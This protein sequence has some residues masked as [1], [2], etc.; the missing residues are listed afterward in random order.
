MPSDR[1]FNRRDFLRST[2][3]VGA[4]GTVLGVAGCGQSS[5]PANRVTLPGVEVQDPFKHGLASGDPT[6]SSVLL[7][8]RVTPTDLDGNFIPGDVTV[9]WSAYR[10]PELTELV[11]G[12]TTIARE[13]ND[14]CVKVAPIAL[15]LST[16]HPLLFIA[17]PLDCGSPPDPA[18]HP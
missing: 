13:A 8:T 17:L 10:D 11:T 4:A 16:P 7:W 15:A 6:S 5:A 18:S 3:A 9:S 14:Y 2:A 1:G 12:G